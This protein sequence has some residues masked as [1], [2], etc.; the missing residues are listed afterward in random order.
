M[1]HRMLPYQV[2]VRREATHIRASAFGLLKVGR[3]TMKRIRPGGLSHEASDDFQL[4]IPR[5]V[6]SHDRHAAV[7]FDGAAHPDRRQFV[8]GLFGLRYGATGAVTNRG[9]EIGCVR[10]CS[11]HPR[12]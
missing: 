10:S 4:G 2:S 11:D 6:R 1:P 9:G 12:H 8:D 3:G 5:F 7:S